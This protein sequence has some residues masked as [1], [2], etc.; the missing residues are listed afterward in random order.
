M[1][2]LLAVL[3]LATPD[4]QSV[5]QARNRT[6]ANYHYSLGLQARFS[7][8]TQQALE[9]YRRA[10]KLDPTAGEIRSEMARLLLEAGKP[11]EALPEAE[12]GVKLDPENG[13]ARFTL[14]RLYQLRAE[15]TTP[16]RKLAFVGIG[17]STSYDIGLRFHH[18]RTCS[19]VMRRCTSAP[20]AR[21]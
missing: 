8:D 9:E 20:K 2:V 18:A 16:R 1:S 7:G 3:L 10:Q 13:E 12:A 14:A 5:A 17:S 21:G 6:E 19:C 11:D 4:N 15:T